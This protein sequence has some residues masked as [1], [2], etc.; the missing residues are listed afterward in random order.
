MAPFSGGVAPINP[1]AEPALD[2]PLGLP[3]GVGSVPHSEPDEAVAW[4]LE[5]F[6]EL[7][8]APTRPRVEPVESMLAQAAWGVAGVKVGVDGRLTVDPDAL[9]VDEPLGDPCANGRPFATMRSF[10]Q[11]I[12][13]R[14]GPVK[15]QVTGP[16]TLGLALRAAGAPDD[17]AFEVAGRA[18]AARARSLVARTRQAA[19]LAPVLAMVDEPG[20][21]G[22]FRQG[23][24]LPPDQVI[25]L[26]SGTLAAVEAH[27]IAGLHCCGPA[28]WR[29]LLQAGPRLLSL[30]VDDAVAAS[31]GAL[32]TFLEQ[33]GWIAWGAVPTGGPLGE[34][35]ARLWRV[36]SGLWCELVQAGCDPV[37]LRRQAIITPVCGLAHH[38]VEQADAMAALTRQV[39]ERLH[40]QVVGVR[41]SV[42]A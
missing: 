40:D 23:F 42:G 26:V 6:P 9:D 33:G 22:G 28:D 5:R 8:A 1:S 38:T 20:L 11:A 29:A 15:V 36:L 37:Q 41:L 12:E 13:G 32:G 24:P 14:T 30:P 27:A 31:A 21:V 34:S 17:V 10:W 7:P 3:T 16:V 19:P 39:A 4:V 2:L 18:A 35:A 25:D